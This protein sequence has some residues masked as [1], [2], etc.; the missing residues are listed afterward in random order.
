MSIAIHHL[1][2]V[3]S[4][5]SRSINFYRRLLDGKT[6]AMAGHTAVTAGDVCIAIVPRR[7]EDPGRYPFG[8]HMAFRVPASERAEL[9]TRL[10]ELGA[11]FDDVRG[12]V[13]TRDPDGL[14]LELVFEP[15]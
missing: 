5:S 14:T 3:S 7:D 4:H 10:A 2:I 8:L 1:G 11:D 6:K 12:R 13:Y 9:L 15:G